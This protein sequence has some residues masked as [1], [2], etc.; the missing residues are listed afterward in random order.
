MGTPG[1]CHSRILAL[2][3]DGSLGIQGNFGQFRLFVFLLIVFT[4][5]PLSRK[6]LI[7]RII[8]SKPCFFNA[9]ASYQLPFNN[10]RNFGIK[11]LGD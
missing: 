4:H 1:T 10:D 11:G 3:Q 7:V 6:G 2:S 8:P 5:L 9:A